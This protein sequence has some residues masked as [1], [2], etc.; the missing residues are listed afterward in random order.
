M[1]KRNVAFD[2]DGII[3]DFC[4]GFYKWYYLH[5]HN[6][7]HGDITDNP[8][9][10]SYTTRDKKRNAAIRRLLPQFINE[11]RDLELI[12]PSIPE[13]MRKINEK[14]NV[15]IVTQYPHY[16]DRIA[17]L[18][19]LGIVEGIHYIKLFCV[20]S[21]NEK[22]NKIKELD[23]IC[24]FED[25]PHIV[26]KFKN[27]KITIRVPRLVNYT[28]VIKETDFIRK[29]NYLENVELDDL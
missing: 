14:Y 3:T 16:D 5:K 13:Y 21:G 8:E 18:K 28:S 11:A 10:Y 22:Y 24:Y 17:N 26:K 19:K 27:D 7:S 9:R 25:A 15:Y 29:Y 12:A 1:D 4:S 6:K 23:P 2:C 20:G